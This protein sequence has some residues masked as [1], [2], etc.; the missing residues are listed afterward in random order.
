MMHE[1]LNMLLMMNE[2]SL[3]WTAFQIYIWNSTAE[4]AASLPNAPSKPLPQAVRNAYNV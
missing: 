4:L 3:M 1:N 2:A